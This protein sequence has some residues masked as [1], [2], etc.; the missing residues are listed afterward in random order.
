MKKITNKE[1][2]EFE[3]YKLSCIYGK[4]LTPDALR[5]ICIANNYDPTEIGKYFLD[6]LGKMNE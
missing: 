1:Y 2:K 4:V 5:M 3:Q 6:V